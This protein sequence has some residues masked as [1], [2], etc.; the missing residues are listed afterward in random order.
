MKRAFSIA[1]AGFLFVF[2]LVG[3]VPKK[4]FAA[5]GLSLYTPYTG[6]S[7][8]PGDSVNY[9]INV[10]NKTS[11]IQ[12]VTF[13]L[14]KLPNTWKPKLT[15]GS[16]AIQKLSVKP[17]G[18]QTLNLNI[19]VPLKISKGDVSFSIEANGQGVS[20]TLPLTLN[21]TK[22]GTYQS[23]FKVDQSSMEGTN[24][25]T[26]T[27][28]AILQNHTAKTQRYALTQRGPN[29]WDTQFKVNGKN[30][31]SVNLKPNTTKTIT[32]SAQPPKNVQEGTYHIPIHANAGNTSASTTLDAIVSGTYKMTVTTPSGNLA[33]TITA[34]HKKTIQVEVKNDGSAPLRHVKL[35]ATTPS[36]WSVD[37]SPQNITTIHAGKSQTVK[38][39]INASN[40][41][42]TG[43]YDLNIT[44]TSDNSSNQANFRVT[45]K[46]SA[47]WGWVGVLII[48]IIIGGVYTLFRRYGRR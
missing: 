27:Y 26:F 37:F 35:T 43:D 19:Q 42:I 44:A 28:S 15:S 1:L 29:G 18:T 39:T 30:V 8:S 36:G 9:S 11:S 38:A 10:I 3:G 21:I 24:Q 22:S 33:T 14:K 23:S 2:L 20:T 17:G 40:K 41:A 47:L 7:V 12:D 34:G 46:T 13:N 5:S 4:S 45:V 31:T 48:L 16:W 25:S 32:V 6:I